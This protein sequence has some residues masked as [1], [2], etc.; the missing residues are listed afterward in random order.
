MTVLVLEIMADPILDFVFEIFTLYG[1]LKCT[2]VEKNLMVF[3]A[4]LLFC[5][6]LAMSQKCI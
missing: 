4:I 1:V 5:P 2:D 6:G 3:F